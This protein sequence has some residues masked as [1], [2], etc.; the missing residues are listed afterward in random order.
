VLTPEQEEFWGHFKWDPESF[1]HRTARKVLA[2][3][4]KDRSRIIDGAFTELLDRERDPVIVARVAKTWLT[5]YQLSVEP[6]EV[7][8]FDQFHVMVRS[9]A[10]DDAKIG[11]LKTY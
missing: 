10:L 3:Q 5:N 11:Q 2:A 8:R 1:T 4:K 6:T 9:I 7:H